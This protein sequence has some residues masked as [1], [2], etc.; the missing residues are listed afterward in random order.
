MTDRRS[1]TPERS[2][3]AR[4]REWN[5]IQLERVKTMPELYPRG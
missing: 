2:D 3:V 1:K 4:I 5:R